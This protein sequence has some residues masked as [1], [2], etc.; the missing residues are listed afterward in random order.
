[1]TH[2]FGGAL[3]VTMIKEVPYA[4]G[5]ALYVVMIKELLQYFLIGFRI[6]V[7]VVS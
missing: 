4:F 1:M 7:Y 2:A 5:G 3:H 6:K